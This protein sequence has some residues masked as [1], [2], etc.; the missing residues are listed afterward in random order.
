MENIKER[1][2]ECEE[3]L[4]K[5]FDRVFDTATSQLHAE[6]LLSKFYNKENR[7]GYELAIGKTEEEKRYIRK[8][9]DKILNEE[10][11]KQKKHLESIEIEELI[12]NTANIEKNRKKEEMKNVRNNIINILLGILEHPFILLI[13]FFIGL[14]IYLYFE[15]ALP[16]INA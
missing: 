9:Y 11:N 16:I 2:L 8:V 7:T 13:L 1:L 6:I 3:E 10:Y 12:K 14:L 4:R 15:I 5:S